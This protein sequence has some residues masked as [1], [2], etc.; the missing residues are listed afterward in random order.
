MEVIGQS[1]LED[2]GVC[3]EDLVDLYEKFKRSGKSTLWLP[4]AST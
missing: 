3:V 4:S 2:E 1:S